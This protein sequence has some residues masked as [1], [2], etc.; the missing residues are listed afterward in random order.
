LVLVLIRGA[1]GSKTHPYPKRTGQAAERGSA[2]GKPSAPAL[3]Q[4]LT[5]CE[6]KRKAIYSGGEGSGGGLT[7]MRCRAVL[8]YSRLV[9]LDVRY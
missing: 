7:E 6:A 3:R 1:T 5:V 8:L 2:F 9:A 4:S